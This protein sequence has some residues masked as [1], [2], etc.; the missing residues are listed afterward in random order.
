M[1]LSLPPCASV[2][3]TS[4]YAARAA[5]CV[6]ILGLVPSL[7][8]AQPARE[9][10]LHAAVVDDSNNLQRCLDYVPQNVR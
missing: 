3:A 10:A 5:A 6:V 2:S 8:A 4:R 1:T 9:A 7:A